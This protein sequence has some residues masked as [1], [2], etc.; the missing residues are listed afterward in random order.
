MKDFKEMTLEEL[1]KIQIELDRQIQQIREEEMEKAYKRAVEL[2][3]ELNAL[4]SKYNIP[5]E[6]VDDDGYKITLCDDIKVP[7]PGEW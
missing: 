7:K 2:V 5:L 1:I 6:S 4:T 3:D